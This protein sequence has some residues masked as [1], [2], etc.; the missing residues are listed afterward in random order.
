MEYN[1]LHFGWFEISQT[2][3]IWDGIHCLHVPVWHVRRTELG[4]AWRW[5]LYCNFMH[6]V[7]SSF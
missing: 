4:T 2:G 1:C 3:D 7:V 5:R 6:G